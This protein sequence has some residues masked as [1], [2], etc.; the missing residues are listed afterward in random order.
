MTKV[1]I[2]GFSIMI[3]TVPWK[4]LPAFQIQRCKKQCEKLSPC[5]LTKKPWG[6]E[7]EISV[8]LQKVPGVALRISPGMLLETSASDIEDLASTNYTLSISA[9]FTN[10][11]TP[12]ST[13][14]I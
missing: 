2:D 1:M 9:V 3:V 6:S 11:T 4:K 8:T 10:P 7:E 13:Q 5:V 14:Y 12:Q